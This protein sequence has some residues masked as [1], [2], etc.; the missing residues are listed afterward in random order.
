MKPLDL[1]T[2]HR[3]PGLYEELLTRRLE[4]ALAGLYCTSEDCSA[5]RVL[6]CRGRRKGEMR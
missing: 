5:M 1:V 2:T 6:L 3:P 4:A